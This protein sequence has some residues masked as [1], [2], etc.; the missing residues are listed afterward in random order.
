MR[1]FE[2]MQVTH[3]PVVRSVRNLR[4]VEDMVAIV[5]V[6]NLFAQR[7]NSLGDFTLG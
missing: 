4:I 7:F 6:A 2:R 5:M 1:L 3:E